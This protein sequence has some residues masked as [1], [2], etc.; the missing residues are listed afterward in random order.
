MPPRIITDSQK[1][2]DVFQP[3]L[4]RGA[5]RLPYDPSRRYFYVEH[6]TDGWRVYL[7]GACFIHELYKP[8]DPERFLV[9]KR[10][11]GNSE[12]AVWEPPKGQMEGKDGWQ[13]D[14]KSIY[15]LLRDNVRREVEEEAK[16]HSLRELQHSGLVL[17]SVEPDFPPNTFFQYHIFSAYATPRAVESAFASFQWFQEHP[18]A[19]ARQRRE[20]KEKDAIAWYEPAEMKI[21]GSWSPTLVAMYLKS[22][23]PRGTAK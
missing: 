8:F 23:A 14:D 20:K 16:I 21:M 22:L 10:T 13:A 9:V 15:D 6:P 17:Q 7:R 19:F 11:G 4:K 12:K 5:E 3:G 1:V 2:F 18:A